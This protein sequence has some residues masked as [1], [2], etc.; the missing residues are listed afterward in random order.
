[1]RSPIREQNESRINYRGFIPYKVVDKVQGKYPLIPRRLNLPGS[2]HL[3]KF[4]ASTPT[5]IP[6]LDHRPQSPASSCNNN[7]ELSAFRFKKESPLDSL[8][9]Y[10]HIE[11]MLI[12]G[13]VQTFL[14]QVGY[15]Q[16]PNQP[17][18]TEEE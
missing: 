13:L 9:K 18:M 6:L 11:C 7:C 8:P 17:V 15:S 5:L 3:K 12:P 14:P 2:F 10:Y 1:M 16:G 4:F